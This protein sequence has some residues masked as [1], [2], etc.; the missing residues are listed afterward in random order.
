LYKLILLIAILTLSV[1]SQQIKIVEKSIYYNSILS[2]T[3]S[4]FEE[5]TEKQIENYYG[6][7]I[8]YF[9][10]IFNGLYNSNGFGVMLNSD[11][12]TESLFN[13]GWYLIFKASFQQ[14]ENVQKEGGSLTLGASLSHH[15]SKKPNSLVFKFGLGLRIPNY[16]HPASIL[17]IEYQ[18]PLSQS[19]YLSISIIEEIVGVRFAQPLISVG[20]L[21]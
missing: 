10:D 12:Y 7:H 21:F 20:I 16:P 2:T 19:I 9:P 3:S 15:F 18:F 1:Y 13:W 4:N 6:I 14:N 17:S 8:G 5:T 11:N